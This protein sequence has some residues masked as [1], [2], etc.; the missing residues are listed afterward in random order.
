MILVLI[1]C[2]TTTD[3][4]WYYF[5]LIVILYYWLIGRYEG[6]HSQLVSTVSLLSDLETKAQ[7]HFL[8]Y[9][10]KCRFPKKLGL[11]VITYTDR[12]GSG[13][14]VIRIRIGAFAKFGVGSRPFQQ[15]C[16]SMTFFW[17]G[18]GSGSA[19]GS[20]SLTNGCGMQIWILLFSSLTFKMPTKN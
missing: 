14:H 12:L 15:C 3:W 8:R 6:H 18:S 17:C 20:M 16:G 19:D 9:N 5:W 2:D 7:D 4:L 10:F 11:F 13:S 1:D